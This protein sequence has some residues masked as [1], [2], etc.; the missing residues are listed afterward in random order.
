M[1]ALF[2]FATFAPTLLASPAAAEEPHAADAKSAAAVV[3]RVLIRPLA[4]KEDDQSRF[5][6]A[7]LPAQERRV[8]VDGE[9]HVDASGKEYLT[10]AVDARHGLLPANSDEGWR[11]DAITGCVYVDGGDVFVKSGDKYRPAAFL[12]GKN[13]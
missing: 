11:R 6:R 10:F 13:V 3:Q 1:L 7:R 8:R 4:A 5:S 9:T 12:L 2:A